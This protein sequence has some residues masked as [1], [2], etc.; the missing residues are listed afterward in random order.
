WAIVNKMKINPDKSK[1]AS[2]TKARVRVRIKYYFGDQLIP[3]VDSVKYLGIIIPSNLNWAVHVKYTLRKAWR[4]LHFVRPIL[5]K[6]NN[7]THLAYTALDRPILEY[8]SVCWDHYRSQIKALNRVQKRAAK[9]ANNT[10]KTG[11]LLYKLSL[12]YLVYRLCA[13]FKAYT[14]RR[15]WGAIGDRLARPCYLSREDHIWK[16]RTKCQRTDIGKHS[17]VNTTILNWN[18]L[19]ADLLRLCLVS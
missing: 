19:P 12:T 8:G 5:K 14:G 7:T 17:F 18:Q 4:A 15:A 10:N 11:G 9:F 13:L 2:F 3:E 16:I 1:S 6:G